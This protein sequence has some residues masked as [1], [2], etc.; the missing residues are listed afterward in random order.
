MNYVFVTNR[1]FHMIVAYSRIQKI[2]SMDN[3]ARFI[4]L[5]DFF[6]E[7]NE[8]LKVFCKVYQFELRES[9]NGNNPIASRVNNSLFYK[10]ANR[11]LTRITAELPEIDY[12]YIFND[13]DLLN[14]NIIEKFKA[15]FSSKVI[16]LD[17]GA[18][19]YNGLQRVGLINYLIRSLLYGFNQNV[20]IG[21]NKNVDVIMCR[22][23]DYL[24]KNNKHKKIIKDEIN[25]YSLKDIIKTNEDLN[26]N[27]KFLLFVGQPL[28]EIATKNKESL[29]NKYFSVLQDLSSFCRKYNIDFVM[30]P[31]PL[32]DVDKYSDLV[33]NGLVKILTTSE[34]IEF[35]VAKRPPLM[36]I[37]PFSSAVIN[38]NA[39]KVP[40]MLVYKKLD[41]FIGE[42]L[43]RF[44][45]SMDINIL[46]QDEN[47]ESGINEYINGGNSDG[48]NI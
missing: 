46:K 36:A 15:K 12:V 43:E 14:Q 25:I 13:A 2:L 40:C 34:P 45:L 23:P 38:I 44:F 27:N 17:E 20:S 47:I 3:E 1:P 10:R 5:T 39:L 4:L 21:Y 24:K 35:F 11:K 30:K 41:Y 6:V 7:N 33:E 37:S 18:G 8:I 29:E 22:Y 31:H 26:I 19:L 16:L 42:E 48:S 9:V 32:E 28:I